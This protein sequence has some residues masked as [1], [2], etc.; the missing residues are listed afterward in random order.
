MSEKWGQNR[1]QNG[2][3]NI[4]ITSIGRTLALLGL[5]LAVIIAVPTSHANASSALWDKY[6]YT[7]TI[8]GTL[9][10]YNPFDL[11]KGQETTISLGGLQTKSN[12]LKEKIAELKNKKSEL[13]KIVHKKWVTLSESKDMYSKLKQKA[14][15]LRHFAG[16]LGGY[17]FKK[18]ELLNVDPTYSEELAPLHKS[19]QEA[20]RNAEK[21][22]EKLE[23]FYDGAFYENSQ[24]KQKADTEVLDVDLKIEKLEGQLK[25][26][27]AL[28]NS[29]YPTQPGGAHQ[30]MKGLPPDAD[31][32]YRLSN[33]N[34][35]VNTDL[36]HIDES[37]GARLIKG[38]MTGV[39]TGG[40][41][42]LGENSGIGFGIGYGHSD[43]TQTDPFGGANIDSN[44]GNLMMRGYWGPSSDLLFDASLSYGYARFKNVRPTFSDE[45]TTHAFGLGFGANVASDFS[46]LWRGEARLGWSG[47]HS[48][49][50]DST[51]TSG[52]YNNRLTSNFGK[53]T[54]SGRLLR[55]F[56]SGNGHI[57]ADAALNAVNNDDSPANYD[58]RPFDAEIGAGIQ[59][60]LG[61]TAVLT[62]RGFIA[63]LGREN[64]DEYGGSLKISFN[65]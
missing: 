33:M 14:E 56:T 26:V 11:T 5:L 25:E 50:K 61:G 36:R 37:D 54:L 17:I 38:A 59:V 13:E 55:K 1:R 63:S 21:A 15:E 46:P 8:H 62:G 18:S 44:G 31:F 3:G 49:R 20:N 29:L 60:K 48:I 28:Q 10:R 42:K 23:E 9:T 4:L 34:W 35:W 19:H 40:D 45:Y 16:N 12:K 22:K 27:K 7:V 2:A 52:F 65:F 51:D 6:G 39:M 64:R 57:F 58:T 30:I 47:S 43:L 41:M 32:L 24:A 53:A